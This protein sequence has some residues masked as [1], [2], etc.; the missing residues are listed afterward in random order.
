MKVD[1]EAPKYP[2]LEVGTPTVSDS[3]PGTGASF[4]LSATVSNVGD[5][6]SPATTLHY[7]RSTDATITTSDTAE[8][9]DDV[10]VLAATG[11]SDQSISLTATTGAYY[12]GACVDAVADESDTT[13]NCSASV[14]VDVQT[15]AGVTLTVT[16]KWVP[17]GGGKETVK[18]AVLDE[19]GDEVEDALVSWLSSHPDVATVDS[20]GVVTG[21]SEGKTTI[22]ATRQNSEGSSSTE[23][24][25]V[26][27]AS[28]I[29]ITPNPLSFDET[30]TFATLKA[31][32]YDANDNEMSPTFWDWFFG[33]Q[34]SGD[35][36]RACGY[37]QV[38]SNRNVCAVDRGRDDDHNAER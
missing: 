9:T 22:K 19:N 8:G 12:Y 31:T 13:D 17:V 35:R 32:I 33:K 4:T 34:G 21:I 11:T 16:K 37:L 6:E 29:E 36:V 28:R 2:D 30:G 10:G 5:G 1:V 20:N 25:V 26:K 14:K 18:A 24:E 23:F 7:Y 3:T 27:R 38:W 15:Q